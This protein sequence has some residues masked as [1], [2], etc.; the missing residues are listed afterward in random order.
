MSTA[1]AENFSPGW[2]R[3]SAG[4]GFGDALSENEGTSFGN[5]PKMTVSVAPWSG[6]DLKT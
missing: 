2:K 1:L 6:P 3:A 4:V 5:L